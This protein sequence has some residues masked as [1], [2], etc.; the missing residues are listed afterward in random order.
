MEL[1]K[2]DTT[3]TMK[4]YTG[5]IGN[6]KTMSPAVAKAYQ[7]WLD[8]RKRCNNKNSMSYRWYGAKG[9]QVE[10]SSR[11]FTSWYLE[12]FKKRDWKQPTVGRIDHSKNYSFDNIEMQERSDNSSECAKRTNGGVGKKPS[13][14]ILVLLRDTLEPVMFF[15]SRKE[16]SEITGIGAKNIW[17]ICN[18][19]TAGTRCGLTFRVYEGGA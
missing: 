19:D 16:A 3:T 11:E 8:Q 2:L 5:P 6:R 7:S 17:L 14:K 4:K 12:Q 10:Y 15:A 1:N 18:G 9:I 13:K